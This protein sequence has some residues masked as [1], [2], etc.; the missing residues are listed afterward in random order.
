MNLRN[1]HY[2]NQFLSLIGPNAPLRNTTDQILAM[3]ISVA[4]TPPNVLRYHSTSLFAPRS[5]SHPQHILTTCTKPLARLLAQPN[6]PLHAPAAP[7]GTNRCG[8]GTNRAAPAR[9]AAPVRPAPRFRLQP[10]LSDA[11]RMRPTP[12]LRPSTVRMGP[13]MRA[14]A[15]QA[16]SPLVRVVG[17]LRWRAH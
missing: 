5:S 2:R 9:R 12:N 4:T 7:A 14:P 10:S 13:A 17:R 1:I 15:R 6:H 3:N 16:H 11:V 8:A